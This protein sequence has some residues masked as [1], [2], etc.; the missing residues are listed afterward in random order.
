M[1]WLRWQANRHGLPPELAS[2]LGDLY[3][4]RVSRSADITARST[5]ISRVLV[6]G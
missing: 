4:A 6:A 2:V 3:A 5:A 1:S